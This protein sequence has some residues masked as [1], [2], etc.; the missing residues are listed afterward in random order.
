MPDPPSYS[1]VRA[2]LRILEG[3]GHVRHEQ[4]GP[5]YVYAPTLPRERAKRSALR[6]LLDTFFDG[7]AEQAVAALL[8]DS[9]TEL[10]DEQL[11]RLSRLID[12]ARK[13]G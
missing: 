3:K 13:E 5:R 7:S 6:H 2:M 9:S 1:A 11:A 10:S 4:D 12:Q 8:D